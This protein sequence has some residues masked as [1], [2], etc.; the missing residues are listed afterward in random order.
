MSRGVLV[1]KIVEYCRLLD[2]CQRVR[3]DVC[4]K[5]GISGCGKQEHVDYLMS[6]VPEEKKCNCPSGPIQELSDPSELED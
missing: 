1:S 6:T 5:L 2:M 4:N 3:C